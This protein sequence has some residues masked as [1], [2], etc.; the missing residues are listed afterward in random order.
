MSELHEIAY[1]KAAL[2]QLGVFGCVAFLACSARD[3]RVA[4]FGGVGLF[5]GFVVPQRRVYA[6]YRS[7]E[8]AFIGAFNGIADHLVLW[9]F[10]GA[11]V[12]SCIGLLLASR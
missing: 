2:W 5:L 12:G 9:A 4:L 6:D 11:S 8:G 3:R 10:V 1:S 7:V